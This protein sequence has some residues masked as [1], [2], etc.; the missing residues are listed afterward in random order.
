[1]ICLYTAGNTGDFFKISGTELQVKTSPLTGGSS[2]ALTLTVTDSGPLSAT[3]TFNIEVQTGMY[4]HVHL[5]CFITILGRGHLRI[6]E[7]R[8]LA[9]C[10]FIRN[11]FKKTRIVATINILHMRYKRFS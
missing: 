10:L 3:E 1:M 4:K 8:M 5:H 7:M 6:L 9:T 2:Y 11:Y